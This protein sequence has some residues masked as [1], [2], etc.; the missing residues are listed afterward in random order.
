MRRA[1]TSAL[2]NRP[3]APGSVRWAQRASLVLAASSTLAVFGCT[4][5]IQG[6]GYDN[7][8]PGSGGS[9]AGNT[10]GNG[11]STSN[12]GQSNDCDAPSK[13]IG[14]RLVRLTFEQYDNSIAQL[15]GPTVLGTSAEDPRRREF[16]ALFV[17]GDLINT[18]IFQKTVQLGETASNTM[19]AGFPTITGCPAANPD[20]ACATKFI[21]HF[22]EQAYRRPLTTDEQTSLTQLYTD[23]KGILGTVQDAVRETTLGVLTAPEVLYR[24]EFGKAGADPKKATLDGY[25]V[26]SSLSYFLLNAPPDAGLLAAA[27]AG[28]LTDADGIGKEVDR[29]LALDSVK[30]N[31]TAVMVAYYGLKGLDGTIKDPGLFPDYTVGV[32]NSMYNETQLFLQDT[33]WKGKLDDLMTSRKTYVNDT[34][35]KFYGVTYPA[36]SGTDFLPFEFPVGQRAGI[37]T[38]GSILSVHAR[39]N[40][41]SVVSRGLFINGA[42]LCVQSPPPPPSS[43]QAQVQA[44]LADMTATER[45]KAHYRDTT[46]PCNSCHVGFDPYGLVLENYDS[47]GRIRS[48]YSNGVAIDTTG[49]L[50]PGAGGGT[51]PDVTGFVNQ[52]TQNEVFSKCMTSNVMK[53]ALADASYVDAQ[54]C[55]VKNI[56]DGFQATGKSFPELI[57]QIAVSSLIS[58]RAIESTP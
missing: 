11:G 45:D 34:L 19:T 25:E 36:A 58:T 47:I 22:A 30:Q 20:D 28:K 40:T 53:Y 31:L 57:R 51:V 12:G 49:V 33:L 1:S 46:K 41:T 7:N 13:P 54:D 3:T 14:Q 48:M 16:Q 32:R 27:A 42:V 24:T 26:A 37:L 10:T 52:V 6:T 56:H 38:H 18:Q 9:G 17:E 43:V 4:S 35:A 5:L 55:N 2:T 44:Q 15:L 50:P 39:T 29:L 21:L 23:T 8:S